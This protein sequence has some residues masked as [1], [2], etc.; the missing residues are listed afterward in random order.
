MALVM[1]GV[2]AAGVGTSTPSSASQP[3]AHAALPTSLT[4]QQ[5]LPDAGAPIAQGSPGRAT[6]DGSGPS[7]V[8]GDRAGSLYAFHLSDGS[9]VR[10]WPARTGAPIDSTPSSSPDGK[11]TDNVFV[12]AGN[13]SQ[14]SAGGYHGFNHV[15]GQIWSNPAKDLNGTHGTQ[16]SLAV[17]SLNGATSVVAPSLGQNA[18]ALNASNG[19]VLSGWPFFTADSGFSTPSL[20]DLYG[21]GQN[22]VIEG[23]DSTAGL[24]NG[25]QY[26]N[27]GHLRVIG[28]GG[29]LICD[30]DFNQTIDSSTAVGSF[31]ANGQVG[32]AFG[33]G[34]FYPGA[35]DSRTLFATDSHCN[36]AWSAN[37]GGNTLS[38]PAIGDIEGG[39]SVQVIEGADTG[40][41]GL[42]WALNGTN[43]A[44]L[45]GWPQATSGRIIGSIVTADLTGLGYN[46]VLVPTTSGLVIFD[47]RSAQVVAT[48]GA[49]AVA[50]QN[51]PMVSIDPNGTIGITIAGYNAQNA[52]TIQHYEVTGS[53]GRSLGKRSWPMF[54]QNSHLTGALTA[55][56]PGHLNEPIAGIARTGDAK[57]YWN[58]AV[59]GGI[60]AFGDAGFHGSM[61]GQHLNKPV[62]GMAATPDGKGYW[63]VASDGGIFAFGDAGFHGSTGNIA[64][65]KPV[66]GMA[67]TPDGKG[68]WLVA[69]D[70][71]IFAFGDAGFHGSTGNIALNEPVVGIA[72][73][74][75]GKGYWFVA[76]DGGIFAFGDARFY[77]S[78]PQLFASQVGV[79]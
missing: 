76:S 3:V 23:G 61:G 62:V 54:H 21:N 77:G 42:V 74:R 29:N 79:D 49:G 57:G 9:S 24:A 18:Y 32:I 40:S 14:P 8:V 26:A 33:T 52:G 13:A 36:V 7:V 34:S 15:G 69:S 43:G 6:L 4:W 30:H 55:A 46:D 10:G 12:G 71:G 1:S 28:A 27:G 38:S 78:I 5:V 60:F 16:A 17:G 45:P 50:L 72:G 59:D 39:G 35:S 25:V 11:G 20:A 41:G 68:Y 67:A 31:L 47:G 65:N 37:L 44:A 56:A 51:A 66:V 73:T 63:L 70:G 48:L 75:D 2:L 58:V 22:E 64:L 53:N 19:G